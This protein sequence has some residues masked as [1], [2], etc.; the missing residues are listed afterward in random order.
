MLPKIDLV[1][2][3]NK[4]S[5]G[6]K[7]GK[8]IHADDSVKEICSTINLLA[9]NTSADWVLFWGN[10]SGDI[11][12]QLLEQL[13]QQHIDVWHAGLKLG[14]N[15][16]PDAINYINPAWIY[17]KDANEDIQNSSFRMSM[18]GCL[19]RT[20]VLRHISQYSF[21]HYASVNML[22]LAIGYAL[23][24]SG[25]IMRYH[26]QLVTNSKKQTVT[27]SEKDEWQFVKQFFPK[28]WQW[29][30]A[31]NK[32]GIISNAINLIQSTKATRLLLQPIIH[33]SNENINAAHKTVSV[34]A[35]TLDRYSYLY[36][37]LEQ[38]SKQTIK[39]IE[40][41]VTD[42]TD[43]GKRQ[44]L[45]SSRFSGLN[46]KYFPQTDKGQCTAWNKLLNEATGDYVLF[47]GDDADNITDGFIEKLLATAIKYNADIVASNVIEIGMPEKPVND[48]YYMS[49]TFPITLAKRDVILKAGGMDMF[50]NK[51]IRADYDLALRCHN[52]GALMIFDSSATI[53]HHRAS[54]GGLR[55]Y[56]ARAI[57]NRLSKNS[58]TR[59]AEPTSS[60][61][62]L[63][64]KHFNEK[65]FKMFVRIKYFDQLIVNGSI[66]KKTLRLL[67]FIWKIPAFI[68]RYK[69][70]LAEANDEL[71]S[72]GVLKY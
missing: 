29:W 28:K 61:L 18:Y 69:Q 66:I 56:N 42:Q 12:E 13:T 50:F 21:S 8:V 47:L 63:V 34:L 1:Y 6:W 32:K 23:I 20:V 27:I 64:K 38:L 54:V 57:T 40:I 24:K 53:H 7:Y 16:L 49:D 17:N 3:G 4:P 48:H 65:Q 14:L 22:G 46:I 35:P 45:D 68:K 10:Q 41:L 19:I 11:D 2:I 60:E 70:R 44:N 67:V 72:R 36:N 58:I 15:G 33:S 59:F 71:R 30:V 39:P 37:E 52:N 31:V 51:N 9:T 5:F 26:P 55:T 43:A 62:F 25:A